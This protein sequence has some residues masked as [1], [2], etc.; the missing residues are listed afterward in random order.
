MN[1]DCRFEAHRVRRKQARESIV[2]MVELVRN[3]VENNNNKQAE[4]KNNGN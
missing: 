2:L 4:D 1:I 3:Q